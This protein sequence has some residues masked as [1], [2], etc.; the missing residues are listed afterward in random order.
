M[1]RFSHIKLDKLRYLCL[2]IFTS[3]EYAIELGTKDANT[4]RS[5]PFK[6]YKRLT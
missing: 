1:A 4:F 6:N 2:G 5:P 3:I